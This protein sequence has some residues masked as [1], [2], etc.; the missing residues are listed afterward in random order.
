MVGVIG[1]GA[2]SC[3]YV[4]PTPVDPLARF[5]D[6]KTGQLPPDEQKLVDKVRTGEEFDGKGCT[7]RPEF[8]RF[9]IVTKD[10]TLGAS[11]GVNLVDIVLSGSLDLA[12]QTIEREIQIKRSTVDGDVII[13]FAKLRVLRLDG[14][15]IRKLEGI[16]VNI[17]TSIYLRSAKAKGRFP[18]QRFV[19]LEQVDLSGSRIDG[20]MSARGAHIGM[21]S[22]VKSGKKPTG[23][24]DLGKKHVLDLSDSNIGSIVLGPKD[25][26]NEREDPMPDGFGVDDC[27]IQGNISFQRAR[28]VSLND[29]K[30]AYA[31]I[32]HPEKIGVRKCDLVLRGFRYENLGRRADRDVTFRKEWLQ[33]DAQLDER[34]DPQPYEQLASVLR[35]QGESG[36]ATSIHVIKWRK[37]HLEWYFRASAWRQILLAVPA[38]L[39][40][41]LVVL[42]LEIVAFGYRPYRVL[43][44]MGGLIILGGLYFNYAYKAGMIE[45]SNILVSRSVIW[46]QCRAL[47][48]N[49]PDFL[50]GPLSL[51]TESKLDACA[52]NPPRISGSDTAPTPSESDEARALSVYPD[53]NGLWYAADIVLPVASLRQKEFWIPRGS[54]GQVLSVRWNTQA[55]TF[56]GWLLS[57]IGIGSALSYLN[58]R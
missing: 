16:R 46:A 4:A 22:H 13:K 42:P 54:A 6:P 45:P 36:A 57:T 12:G 1:G 53:F 56:L 5:Y 41:L 17:S 10:E 15:T 49:E 50:G 29:G 55:L 20:A 24:I 26:A 31:H 52:Q 27:I 3:N 33:A 7:I 19:A 39:W 34:F 58:R 11:F 9:I 35:S 21:N 48:E 51:S 37:L 47:A 30:I 32:V 14:S 8:L 38:A 43:W 28:C 23:L 18:H 25:K 44:F 40:W 2:P